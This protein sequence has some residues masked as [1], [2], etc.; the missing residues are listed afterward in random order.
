MP[1]ITSNANVHLSC[2]FLP[3][4][5]CV[6]AFVHVC[7]R[8]RVQSWSSRLTCEIMRG[9]LS[10]M[11]CSKAR[12]LPQ[13]IA[14][15]RRN[16]KRLTFAATQIQSWVSTSIPAPLRP[17]WATALFTER[18]KQ[19]EADCVCVCVCSFFEEIPEFGIS[20]KKT[21]QNVMTHA[22]QRGF[23]ENSTVR[24][25]LISTKH[26][27]FLLYLSRSQKVGRT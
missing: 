7:Q 8:V 25:S 21:P 10:Q 22:H 6:R 16:D 3:L 23:K 12:D 9:H 1:H 13:Q 18:T 24:V 19:S 17:I 27:F 5:A 2:F 4:C 11:L 15:G 14:G 20:S 26:A